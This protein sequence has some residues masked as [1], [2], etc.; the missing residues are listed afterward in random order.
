M[1][2]KCVCMIG[3]APGQIL[4]KLKLIPQLSASLYLLC[5]PAFFLPDTVGCRKY[6]L[7]ALGSR[8][9]VAITKDR[10]TNLMKFRRVAMAAPKDNARQAAGLGLQRCEI[11]NAAF[12]HP[13]LIVDDENISSLRASDRLQKDIH[14]AIMPYG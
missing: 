7:Q 3:R 8:G 10:K 9:I 14:A 4:L 11:P 2:A 5:L 13:A 12:I 1:L 6:I